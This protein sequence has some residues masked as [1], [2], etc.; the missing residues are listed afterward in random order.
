MKTG[1]CPLAV[2]LATALCACSTDGSKAAETPATDTT[3]VAAVTTETAAAAAQAEEAPDVVEKWGNTPIE[4]DATMPTVIDFNATWCGPCVKFGPV[5]HAVAAEY[6]GKAR[7][8]SVDVDDARDV[9]VKFG[10]SSIPQISVLM[11]DGTVRSTVGYMTADEFRDFL[12]K[13]LR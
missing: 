6:A 2:W 5:Y 7:F 12:A 1:I 11:P 9:A 10:V 3:A 13:A 4:P 8:L